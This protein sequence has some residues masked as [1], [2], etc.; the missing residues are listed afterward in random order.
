MKKR[1]VLID[2]NALIHRSFHALPPL[3]T[4][5]GELVNAVYGFSA[6]LLRVL[7]ELK[8]DYIV[9]AFDLPK[10][11]FR[12]LE[13]EAYKATRPKTAEEL[14]PQFSITKEVLKSFDIP[15][16][17]KEG[18]EADDIIGTIVEKTKDDIEDIIVTGD[19]DTLQ[20][21][22]K[23]TK[24]YTLKKG[25]N[26]TIV[27]DEKAVRERYELEP[28]QIIDFKGLKGDPSDN[29][30][31]VKGIGEKT[32]INLLKEFGTIENLYEKL[33]K[34]QAKNIPE[35]LQK[36]LKEN[37]EQAIFSKRLA[38]IR[39]D[40]PIKFDL[41]SCRVETYNPKDVIKIF[42]D[43]DFKSLINRLPEIK[44]TEEPGEKKEKSKSRE[45]EIYQEIEAAYKDKILSSKAYKLE[46]ELA[47]VLLGMEKAG[48]KLDIK[49]L[50]DLSKKLN[51]RIL[52]LENKIYKLAGISFNINSSQ[53]LSEILFK[54]LNISI[55]GLRKTPGG[56]I[57][58]A[59]PELQKLKGKH[60]II[61]LILDYRELMKLKT[62][63]V[64]T[65]PKLVDNKTRI[66]TVYHQLGTTTG[67]LS[68]SDPNLQNIPARGQWGE[69]IRK[70][71]IA[72]KGYKLLSADYS[73]IELRIAACLAKDK[74]MLSAFKKNQDIHKITAAEVNNVSLE[75]VTDKM[76]FEAKALNFG[77][78]YGMSV[79]GFSEA[80]GISRERAKKFIDEYMHDFIGIAK[81]VEKT[82]KE[83]KKK[84]YV[85]TVLG[86]RR[87]LPQINS[88]DFLMRHASE[89]MAIN[90]PVQGTAA[91]IMKVA[92]I[93]LVKGLPQEA[94]LLLQVH[95]ELVLEV[96]ED[97][98]KETA[99]IV[100]DTMEN[101]L[102]QQIFKSVKS[103]FKIPLKADIKVGDNWGEL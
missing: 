5:K 21:I 22:N 100:K 8:P 20:L 49:F 54:K 84:G 12:H 78:L 45:E 26:D 64:D 2:A 31:G 43:L 44:K 67:R 40:A 27:Y 55:D 29:I 18:F 101:V 50:A 36:K 79:V 99:E 60:K 6:I 7:R 89:R 10:P 63:Y 68:S 74:K 11:T 91:D 19:L 56:V 95:D 80:A 32:A 59:A 38:T 1:L 77:V 72:E 61:D 90:M 33:E 53:Q 51:S 85:E 52:E 30:P 87:Y 15:I 83:A 46:K 88:S 41:E 9:T 97:K 65:L 16:I 94:R 96:K 102:N 58:T 24:V 39:R 66:H 92:M 69:K 57:S 70:A 81:Y 62:T 75:K 93:K 35:S 73:Q 47:P 17:E 48:I 14:I 86:R 103:I 82:K 37:K 42:Q 71:F 98:I 13:Y 3:T 28:E 25:I 34:G 4:K 76:R 23:N